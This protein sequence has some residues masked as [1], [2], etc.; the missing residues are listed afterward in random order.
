MQGDSN[1]KSSLKSSC[2]LRQPQPKH[3]LWGHPV[4]GQPL[5]V[6]SYAVPQP[7]SQP[8]TPL[9]PLTFMELLSRG[10][11]LVSPPGRIRPPP[12]PKPLFAFICSIGATSLGVPSPLLC[13]YQC[14]CAG[15]G[16]RA[17]GWGLGWLLRS[18]IKHIAGPC[19]SCSLPQIFMVPLWPSPVGQCCS[20]FSQRGSS[21]PQNTAWTTLEAES[22]QQHLSLQAGTCKHPLCMLIPGASGQQVRQGS[23]HTWHGRGHK[24]SC[25]GR[26]SPTTQFIGGKSRQAEN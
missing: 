15:P 16:S 12:S 7:A 14:L 26:A 11:L 21:D 22:I 4:Q 13:T 24:I 9:R 19:L 8:D 2:G 5:P 6:T 17:N 25:P 20:A 18:S 23:M 1:S 10:G 3:P